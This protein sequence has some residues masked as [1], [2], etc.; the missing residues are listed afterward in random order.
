MRKIAVTAAL[1]LVAVST[2]DAQSRRRNA[3]PPAAGGAR[4]ASLTELAGFEAPSP[5]ATLSCLCNELERVVTG[6]RALTRASRQPAFATA[7]PAESRRLQGTRDA[8]QTAIEGAERELEQARGKGYLEQEKR[9]GAAADAIGDRWREWQPFLGENGVDSDYY[10]GVKASNPE[11][12]DS[13]DEEKDH[14]GRHCRPGQ[15]WEEDRALW[16]ISGR[17]GICEQRHYRIEQVLKGEKGDL[18]Y[19]CYEY[20]LK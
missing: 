18:G 3:E 2:L 16:A 10:R 20:E 11:V 13:G 17:E 1:A 9:C 7:F 8:L 14:R 15:W 12:P 4:A 5:D 19:R 6:L